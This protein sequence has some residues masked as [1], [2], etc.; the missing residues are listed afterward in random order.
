MSS[1]SVLTA[2]SVAVGLVALW[3]GGAKVGSVRQF[4]FAISRYRLLP[5]RAAVPAAYGV[6]TAELALGTA[7]LT[8]S[9][10][11]FAALAA[12]ALFGTFAI[13][14]ALSLA[15]GM[16]VPCGCFGGEGEPISFAA[17]VRVLMLTAAAGTIAALLASDVRPTTDTSHLLPLLFIGGGITLIVR[18]LGSVPIVFSWYLRQPPLAPAPTSRVSLR[19]LA[20]EASLFS[21]LTV[22]GNKVTL[23]SPTNA[24]E[25]AL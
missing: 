1:A 2:L 9:A 24:R 8:G 19:H 16:R 11:M 5:V 20:P 23:I 25:E 15:K 18:F 4:A 13:I 10:L 7:L 22:H 17:L 3:A 12:T 6:V 14:L 21:P